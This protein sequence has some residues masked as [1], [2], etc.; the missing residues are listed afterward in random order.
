MVAVSL[1]P[2]VSDDARLA[3]VAAASHDAIVALQVALARIA[4]P[5]GHEA[6]RAAHMAEQLRVSGA[7]HVRRDDV[8]NVVARVDGAD[9]DAA[10]L[11][12]VA[13]LD[14]VFAEITDPAITWQDG[15]WV[16]PG[17]GD[18]ARGLAV[19][20]MLPALLREAAERPSR[21]IELVATVGEE[22]HGDL[23][24][25][26]HYLQW[27]APWGV[28]ALDSPG[29]DRIVTRGLGA[30][31]YRVIA[32]GPGGHSWSAYGSASALDAAMELATVLRGFGEAPGRVR[33]GEGVAV[34]V[35]RLAGGES[36]NSIPARAE[37]ELDVRALDDARLDATEERIRATVSSAR[38][39]RGIDLS[40]IRSGHRSAGATA[41]THPLVRAA[42]DATRAI[43]REPVLSTGS[44]DANAAMAL[45]IPAI[46]IG[47]GGTGGQAHTV[48]EWFDPHDG[49]RGVERLLH[50]L[51]LVD[52]SQ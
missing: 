4:A 7:A 6:A 19:L 12:I 32:T 18:N 28:I 37:L 29:D 30:R 22:G 26:R 27:A 10:P 52:T 34:T 45:G 40:V 33:R 2:T 14:T 3:R 42:F 50:L 24:G 48:H 16:G 39:G 11:S 20:C 43:G 13:H 21:P 36:I 15:R 17:I 38:V 47:A 46:A 35:A 31:R 41:E 44:T 23:R 5:T 1:S 49:A 9:A 25:I 8:G 51:H